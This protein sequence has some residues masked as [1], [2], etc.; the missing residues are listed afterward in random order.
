MPLKNRFLVGL[1][2]LLAAHHKLESQRLSASRVTGIADNV[3]EDH[4]GDLQLDLFVHFG[5]HW[6]RIVCAGRYRLHSNL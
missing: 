6:E 1:L 5:R 3:D 4:I 2:M